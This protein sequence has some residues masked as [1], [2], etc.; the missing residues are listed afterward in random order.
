MYKGDSCNLL[1]F[2]SVME[3]VVNVDRRARDTWH[4]VG[5]ASDWD[6][7]SHACNGLSCS[8]RLQWADVNQRWINHTLGGRYSC[9]HRHGVHAG[10]ASSDTAATVVRHGTATDGTD[11]SLCRWW[12]HTSSSSSSSTSSQV[13]CRHSTCQWSCIQWATCRNNQ[14]VYVNQLISYSGL[15]R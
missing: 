7:I 4:V 3:L 14:V 13:A 1:I 2:S 5:G 6:Q 15:M 8:A 12:R 9:A 11:W 10:C